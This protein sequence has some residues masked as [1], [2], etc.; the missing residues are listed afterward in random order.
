MAVP[1][2]A[3]LASQQHTT[4]IADSGRAAGVVVVVRTADIVVTLIVR[5]LIVVVI[6]LLPWSLSQFG[7][8]T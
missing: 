2:R 8:A 3:F 7:T 1:S 4:A 5:W 6:V